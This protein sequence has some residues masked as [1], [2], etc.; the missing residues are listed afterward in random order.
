MTGGVPPGECARPQPLVANVPALPAL[1][2]RAHRL[3]PAATLAVVKA[4]LREAEAAWLMTDGLTGSNETVPGIYGGRLSSPSSS[5]IALTGYAV[6]HGI[7]VSGRLKIAKPGPP[8]VFDGA[9]TVS[10][11]AAA[12][13]VLGVKG[14]SLRG[15]LG[16]KL[17]G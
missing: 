13:G 1:P 8:L 10:G 14:S 2:A 5:S 4:T 15:T 3:S 9:L 11:P 6:A 7:T 17:V 12:T 16:G